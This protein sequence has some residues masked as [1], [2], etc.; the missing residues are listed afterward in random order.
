[1]MDR[2]HDSILARAIQTAKVIPNGID[3]TVFRP[4][5]RAAMRSI[6]GLPQ[7]AKIALFA[8]GGLRRN[9]F[10]DYE[11]LRLALAAIGRHFPRG[12]VLFVGLGEGT[13]S[14]IVDGVEMRLVPFESDRMRVAAYY[15]AADVYIHAAKV[16]T[17]PNATLEASA[18][19]TPVIASAVGGI[20]EQLCDGRLGILVPAF[21]SSAMASKLIQ[22]LEDEGLR[23]QLGSRAADHVR[24]RYGRERMAT[25]YLEWFGEILGRS[26]I[27][28]EDARMDETEG[29]SMVASCESPGRSIAVGRQPLT[30]RSRHRDAHP[31]QSSQL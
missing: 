26:S 18:C 22:L 5:D 8:A 19:G 20:V 14:E 30:V 2:V 28:G 31:G 4:A 13:A 12:Q 17:F 1:L 16:E 25:A 24:T 10:K 6:L 29:L 11:T 21:D 3:V 23:W 9:P 7:T 15:Q 27:R